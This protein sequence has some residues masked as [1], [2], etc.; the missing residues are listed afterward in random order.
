MKNQGKE[1]EYIRQLITELGT[2]EP[3][4]NFR[5]SILDKLN[6]KNS[7]SIYKPVIS[8]FTWKLIGGSIAAIVVIV[9]LFV[10]FSE[11]AP[12]QLYQLSDYA[13]PKFSISFP[14][15]SLPTLMLPDLVGQSIIAFCVLALL[16]V[17]SSLKRWKIS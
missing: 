3:S 6:Q 7:V 17:V 1:D 2:D 13:I 14:K 5:R 8:S 4:S 10:P 11:N 16:T 15:I 12:P 9:L